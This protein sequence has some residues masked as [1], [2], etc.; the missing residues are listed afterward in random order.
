LLV[1]FCKLSQET[2]T[3]RVWR[4]HDERKT[5]ARQV[6]DIKPAGPPPEKY[7]SHAAGWNW[8]S[9][10]QKTTTTFNLIVDTALE[11]ALGVGYFIYFSLSRCTGIIL[12]FAS[13]GIFVH[14]FKFQ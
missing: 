10:A 12:I 3:K 8:I 2:G 1:F 4:T 14:G 9:S 6:A 5:G 11:V 7:K 13:S